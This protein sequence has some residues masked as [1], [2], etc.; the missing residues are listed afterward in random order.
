MSRTHY[1]TLLYSFDTL[2]A[3]LA[4][5]RFV[6]QEGP[7]NFYSL[8][9]THNYHFRIYA[10]MFSGQSKVALE[11]VAQ[12]EKSF[13]EE[14]LRVESPPMA[15]WLEAFLACVCMFSYDSDYGTT[16]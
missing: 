16:F 13:P 9:R 2:D 12:I 14:L 6:A 1:S 4:D 11:S 15:D 3:I 5:E 8:Y 7:L 10:A